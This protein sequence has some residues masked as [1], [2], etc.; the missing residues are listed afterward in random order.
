MNITIASRHA[1]L[2]AISA[3]SSVVLSGCGTSPLNRERDLTI[4]QINQEFEQG[5]LTEK[6]RDTQV[7]A[8]REVYEEYETLQMKQ[9]WAQSREAQARASRSS[10]GFT[11]SPAPTYKYVYNQPTQSSG[12]Y[13]PQRP[14]TYV[15]HPPQQSNAGYTPAAPPPQYVYH[16]Q[17]EPKG[18]YTPP[19]STP[20]YVYQKPTSQPAAADS[21]SRPPTYVSNQPVS[22]LTSSPPIA[23]QRKYIT[24][25][26][27]TPAQQQI[28]DTQTPTPVP[29]PNVL[30][31]TLT[32][33]VAAEDARNEK[34]LGKTGNA[35]LKKTQEIVVDRYMTKGVGKAMTPAAAKATKGNWLTRLFQGKAKDGVLEIVGPKPTPE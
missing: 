29:I 18:G 9:I 11:Y 13:T 35:L 6:Q 30:Q 3:I 5:L 1:A 4:A 34:V 23:P 21:S 26:E 15:Y 22:K 28:F 19:P 27:M 32:E 8:T 7:A 31:E 14:P 10:A 25:S 24:R 20:Q 2:W 17:P 16:K 12:G 33:N